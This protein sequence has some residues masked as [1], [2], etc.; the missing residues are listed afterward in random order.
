[1][2]VALAVSLLSACAEMEVAE[3]AEPRAVVQRRVAARP[4]SQSLPWQ[5]VRL[6]GRVPAGGRY[7]LVGKVEGIASSGDF[8]QATRAARIDLRMQALRRGASIVTIDVVKPPLESP[9]LTGPAVL[10]AG[11]AYALAPSR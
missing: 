4:Q 6:V 11:R 9:R 10:L 8:V 7:R 1:M 2:A 3:R 5:K